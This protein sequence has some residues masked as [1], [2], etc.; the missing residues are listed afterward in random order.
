MDEIKI[1]EACG[2]DFIPNKFHPQQRYCNLPECKRERRNKYL[3]AYG[4]M[5]GLCRA[6]HNSLYAEFRIMPSRGGIWA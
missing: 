6:R 1:C 2:K 3:H 4:K 5:W